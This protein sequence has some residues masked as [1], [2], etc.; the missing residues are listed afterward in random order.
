MFGVSAS[1]WPT[2]KVRKIRDARSAQDVAPKPTTSDQSF[3][4]NR[5]E[6][7]RH[8]LRALDNLGDR[9]ERAGKERAVLTGSITRYGNA[10]GTSAVRIIR[11]LPNKLRYEEQTQKG[12]LVLGFDG[13]SPWALNGAPTSEQ[14]DFIISLLRDSADRFIVGQALGHPT[15]M[16]GEKYRL[17]DGSNTNYAG[18]FYDIFKVDDTLVSAGETLHRPTF[19]YINS[20]TGLPERIVYERQEAATIRVVVELGNWATVAGQKVPTKISRK[21]D[22]AVVTEL[23]IG[24]AIISPVV[25]DGIFIGPLKQ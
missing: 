8:V 25:S 9:F 15:R 22:G 23:T 7:D 16:L 4:V 11:E 19:F 18:H 17:D 21:E 13:Q 24:Q 20:Q 10:T 14:I 2:D 6:L 12:Q 5:A 1:V 3:G